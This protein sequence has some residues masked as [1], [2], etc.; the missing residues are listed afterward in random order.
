M[1]NEGRLL[2]FR[3]TPVRIERLSDET[4]LATIQILAFE[5]QGARWDVAYEDV[6]E[7]QF[8]KGCSKA[9]LRRLNGSRK[10]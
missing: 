1:R 4:G 6:G 3:R 10:R 7:Y 2:D 5:D 8:K 9:L